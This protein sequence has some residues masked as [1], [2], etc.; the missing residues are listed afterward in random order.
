MPLSHP[1]ESTLAIIGPGRV[2]CAMSMWVVECGL[3][4]RLAC[5][6][7]VHAA[8]ARHRIGEKWNE[9]VAAGRTTRTAVDLG[10]SRLEVCSSWEEALVGASI[11]FE[12]LPENLALKREA[13][14]R[15]D[16]LAS[17]STLCL[18]GSSSLS[19]GS[20][21]KSASIS[22]HRPLLAF[23]VFLPLSR[24][25]VVE[26]VYE[27]DS[28]PGLLER[29]SKLASHLKKRVVPI[30]DQPG[31]AASRMALA[32]GLEAMRILEQGFATAKDID[33][34]MVQGYGHPCGPLE[35]SDRVGL[36]LRLAIAEQL[37]AET[38][39]PRFE[40]PNI[41]RHKVARGELGLAPGCGFYRWNERGERV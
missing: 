16:G 19:L 41:L 1:P 2:G 4:V 39:D 34:L 37:Y 17:P 12:A 13:W 23:H 11:L 10:G 14:S 18:T 28:P 36:D 22:V 20:I 8:E 24:M 30:L 26:L 38:G 27:K 29:A 3:T 32:Q 15:L 31:Y 25:K 40:P 33:A 7:A 21:R 9:Q 5:R 35:L 6:D